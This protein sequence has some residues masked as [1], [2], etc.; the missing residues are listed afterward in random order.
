MRTSVR[1]RSTKSARPSVTTDPTVAAADTAWAR[2]QAPAEPFHTDARQATEPASSG[3]KPPRAALI[4]G[5][6]ALLALGTAALLF[7]RRHR[8]AR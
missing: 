1:T 3:P 8:T 4:T 6:A 7:T 5:A 2:T